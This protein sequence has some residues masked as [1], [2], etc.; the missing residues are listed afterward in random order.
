[1]FFVKYDKKINA[2]QAFTI[3]VESSTRTVE[4]SKTSTVVSTFIVDLSTTT[5]DVF[6]EM[7]LQQ[8]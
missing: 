2:V 4:V 7:S 1:M 8:P 6:T 3:I 5:V